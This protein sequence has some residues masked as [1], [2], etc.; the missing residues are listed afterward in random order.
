MSPEH[1]TSSIAI[2]EVHCP[3]RQSAD[4]TNLTVVHNN[5][6]EGELL[7]VGSYP[8]I[9][10][11]HQNTTQLRSYQIHFRLKSQGGG[12]KTRIQLVQRGMRIQVREI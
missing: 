7:C 11:N 10:E 5:E 3:S 9:C 8:D 12:P 4:K 1:T 2:G 6:L